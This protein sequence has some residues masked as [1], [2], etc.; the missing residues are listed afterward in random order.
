MSD[1]SI[2]FPASGHKEQR[3]LAFDAPV[4]AGYEWPYFVASGAADGPTLALIAG[5]HGAEYPPIDAVIRFCRDLD[6]AVLCGRV[7]AV[8]VVNLPAFWERTPF[9]CPRDGKNPNRVFPGDPHGSFSEVLAHA[10]FETVIRR[11]DYLVD[12]HAGDMVEDLAPF[13]LVQQTGQERVDAAALGLATAFALPYL[14]VQAPSGGPV[15]GT[16]NAAAAQAGIPAVIA[17]AGGVGQLQAEAV[18]LHLRGLSRVLRRLGMLQGEL[19]P[20]DPPALMRDFV[21]LRAEQGGFFRK[22]IVAGDT[23]VAGASIGQ[24]V[25]LWGEPRAE[26]RTP[27]GGVVLF[28]TTSPA[29][30]DDG[31]LVGIGVPQ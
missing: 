13:S 5:I 12:L 19:A 24:M 29:I 14:V 21:W 4:L 16:T 26:V 17:E 1:R 27:V 31:L 11:G 3:L 6:P 20:L 2:V 23:V 9:V 10:M 15:A 30:A 7:V 25:D 28:V 8:P 18:A 22:T